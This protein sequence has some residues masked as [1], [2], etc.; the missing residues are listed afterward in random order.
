MADKMTKLSDN[1]LDEIVG[2]RF[3][4]GG[5]GARCKAKQSSALQ[6]PIESICKNCGKTYSYTPKAGVVPTCPHC[7]TPNYMAD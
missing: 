4:P 6:S 3:S 2:G 1:E 5:K 7:K